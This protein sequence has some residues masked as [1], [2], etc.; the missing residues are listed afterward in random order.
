MPAVV[1]RKN[2]YQTEAVMAF[3]DAMSAPSRRKYY[4]ALSLLEEDGVLGYPRAEKVAGH[5]NLFEIRI[6]TPGNE[7]FF[8]CYDAGTTIYVVHAFEK[9]TRKTPSRE[10]A[11]AIAIRNNLIGGQP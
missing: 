3:A 1:K 6:I 4:A 2:I 9:R 7:R 10:I 5:R 11:K 8:Y